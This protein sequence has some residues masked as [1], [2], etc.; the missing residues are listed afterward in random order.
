MHV[1]R[2]HCTLL[3]CA[4]RFSQYGFRC[5]VKDVIT[6]PD[7]VMRYLCCMYNVSLLSVFLLFISYHFVSKFR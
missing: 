7:A 3:C 1:M 4:L 5:Y 2:I 6:C